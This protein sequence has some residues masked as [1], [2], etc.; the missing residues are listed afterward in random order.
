MIACFIDSF[1]HL[2][3][4]LF[5]DVLRLILSSSVKLLLEIVSMSNCASLKKGASRTEY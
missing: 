4:D 3:F 2:F 1:I 5:I